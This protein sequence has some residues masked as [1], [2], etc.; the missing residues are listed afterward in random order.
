MEGLGIEIKYFLSQTQNNLVVYN[1][2]ISIINAQKINYA[3][4]SACFLF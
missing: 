2:Y 4:E 1:F 3:E